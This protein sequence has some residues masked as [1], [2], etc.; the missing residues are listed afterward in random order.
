[1]YATPQKVCPYY[2]ISKLKQFQQLL[3]SQPRPRAARRTDRMGVQEQPKSGRFHQHDRP[4]LSIYG[5]RE[6]CARGSRT[7][8]QV[9]A[10][11]AT[12]Q[13]APRPLPRKGPGTLQKKC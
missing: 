2:D 11:A 13:G 10:P 3:E 9:R 8:W 7:W 12:E 4:L 1:M 6:K 5:A